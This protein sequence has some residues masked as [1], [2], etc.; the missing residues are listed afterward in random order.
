M[1]DG[2]VIP[3]EIHNRGEH[4]GRRIALIHSLAMNLDFW[5]PVA[6]T[7]AAD[8]EVLVYDC[9]G[10]GRASKPAGP[11][12]VALFADDLAALLDA[13]SWD[14][15]VVAGASM[16]GCIALAFAAIHGARARALGLVDT[17]AWYGDDASI[18]WEERAQRALKDGLDSLLDFQTARW[19]GEGF[20][21]ARPDVVDAAVS[22][23][24]ANDIPAYAETCRMLGAVDLR[25]SLPGI[26]IPVRIVVGEE[27]YGTPPSAS[28]AMRAAIAGATMRV[29]P[30][31]RHLTPLEVPDD[32]AAELK[33][34]LDLSAARR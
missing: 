11:Y 34:L 30:G 27:D 9:R 14:S 31:A 33:A 21:A 13:V 17:T 2:A 22:V 20:R 6:E 10:H 8:A 19:F 3:Y 28:E 7:L 16:G 23:F 15:A 18:A 25:A 5:R 26:R 4:P 24:R 1:S 12:T 32:I 29:I